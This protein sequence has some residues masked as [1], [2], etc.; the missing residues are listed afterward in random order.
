MSFVEGI[1]LELLFYKSDQDLCVEKEESPDRQTT[2]FTSMRPL[3]SSF[4][5]VCGQAGRAQTLDYHDQV[6]LSLFFLVCVV[7]DLIPTGV[8]DFHGISY[9]SVKLS[10][11]CGLIQL[12][13]SYTPSSLSMLGTQGASQCFAS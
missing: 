5:S 1:C 3:T 6:D 10:L 11:L 8:S 4:Q 9:L 2:S 13:G 12:Y 7:Y